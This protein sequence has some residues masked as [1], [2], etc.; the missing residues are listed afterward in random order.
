MNRISRG[1]ESIGKIIAPCPRGFTKRASS[2]L[3]KAYAYTMLV[4]LLLFT[5]T[6]LPADDISGQ[7]GMTQSVSADDIPGELKITHSVSA[8]GA[9]VASIPIPTLPGA[10]GLEPKLL[11]SYSSQNGNIGFGLG[12]ALNGY[13][14]IVRGSKTRDVDG[15]PGPI[16]YHYDDAFYL[17]GERIVPI[18]QLSAGDPAGPWW[19]PAG[20]IPKGAIEYRKW[21]DDGTLVVAVLSDGVAPYQPDVD[22]F[23]AETK[24]GIRTEFTKKVGG[25]VLPT[26][27]IY[28]PS[29]SIDTAGNYIMWNFLDTG[30]AYQLSSVEYTGLDSPQHPI[31]SFAT[32]NFAYE[33]A[34]RS[35]LS[36]LLGQ[37]LSTTQRLKTVVTALNG[38][39]GVAAKGLVLNLSYKEA[40]P[41]SADAYYLSGAQL[42]ALGDNVPTISFDYQALPADAKWKSLDQAPSGLP[43]LAATALPVIPNAAYRLGVSGTS[44]GCKN[45][46]VPAL[47]L[48]T[49]SNGKFLS[50]TYLFSA[51]NWTEA[52]GL[53]APPVPFVDPA[54]QPMSLVLMDI[55]GDK[56]TDLLQVSDKGLAFIQNQN[57]W[58]NN[59]NYQLSF[60]KLFK[61]S[62][63]PVTPVQPLQVNSYNN[64]GQDLL[65]KLATGSY[66]VVLNG[67]APTY[68]SRPPDP[69][70]SF[71]PP[72]GNELAIGDFN[73]D[74]LDDRVELFVKGSTLSLR[75][76]TSKPN[77]QTWKQE[78]SAAWDWTAPVTGLFH[79]QAIKIDSSNRCDALL[80]SI[81]DAT[82][83]QEDLFVL[84]G[85]RNGW[86]AKYKGSG[87]PFF[88][89]ND[90]TA[91]SPSFVDV[92]GDGRTDVI[93]DQIDSHQSNFQQTWIQSTQVS[94][95]IVSWTHDDTK[96][97]PPPVLISNASNYIVAPWHVASPGAVIIALPSHDGTTGATYISNASGW[98]NTSNLS[99]VPSISLVTTKQNR[100]SI[101][102]VDL[103]GHGLQDVVYTDGQEDPCGAVPNSVDPHCGA[104]FNPVDKGKWTIHN[105]FAPIHPLAKPGD[106]GAR[107]T[108]IDIN[109]DGYADLVY[110]YTENGNT[111]N[112]IYLNGTPLQGQGC[113]QGWV[114]ND[115][116]CNSWVL[117][118]GVVFTDVARGDLGCRFADIDGDGLPDIICSVQPYDTNTG[119]EP[120]IKAKAYI[121]NARGGPC[122]LP[123]VLD[124]SG[125][126]CQLLPNSY[127]LP[128]AFAF[129]LGSGPTLDLGT[130]LI[131][132]DGD[133][134]P[135]VVAAYRDPLNQ[136]QRC[137]VC[138]IYR[139]NG[140]TFASNSSGNLPVDP[141]SSL[142]LML[143]AEYYPSTDGYQIS[144]MDIDGDGLPD[145]VQFI[146][147]AGNVPA[148]AQ[149][150]LGNGATWDSSVSAWNFTDPTNLNFSGAQFVDVNGDGRPDVI[151]NVLNGASGVILNTGNGWSQPDANSNLKP[152]LPFVSLSG[153]DLGVRLIDVTGDGAPDQIQSTGT[154]QAAYS[155]PGARDGMLSFVK[156]SSSVRTCY[157]YK[158]LVD[159]GN[160]AP[161]ASDSTGQAPGIPLVPFSP[162]VWQTVT[163][164][165]SDCMSASTYGRR[166][167]TSYAYEEFR[168]DLSNSIALGF[169]R[170][171][172]TD[173][174]ADTPGYSISHVTRYRQEPHLVG[175]PRLEQT[176]VKQNGHQIVVD[177]TTKSWD[178]LH[179]PVTL[180]GV[181]EPGYLQL[182]LKKSVSKTFDLN[183][184]G[185]IAS[186]VET[187]FEYDGWLNAITVRVTKPGR[188]IQTLVSKY[189]GA[190]YGRY[191]RLT[192]SSSTVTGPDGQNVSQRT[193]AFTYF[194]VSLPQ[195]FLLKTEAIDVGDDQLNSTT[196]YKRDDRGDIITTTKSAANYLRTERGNATARALTP[197]SRSESVEYDSQQLR[198][199]IYQTNAKNQRTS[200]EYD[201][202]SIGSSLALP[203]SSTDPNNLISTKSYDGLGRKA[204][205]STPD[206]VLHHF[207]RYQSQQIPAEWLVGISS[208]ATITVLAQTAPCPSEG[209][210]LTWTQEPIGFA[211]AEQVTASSGRSSRFAG[212]KVYDARNR[213][214]RTVYSR[215][216]GSIARLAFTDYKYD[217]QGRLVA[218]SLAYFSGDTPHWTAYA[219]DALGRRTLTRRPNGALSRFCYNVTNQGPITDQGLKETLL[220][221]KNHETVVQLNLDGKPRLITRSDSGILS[222]SYDGM[223]RV[224]EVESPTHAMT[225][226]E[227]DGLGNRKLVRDPNAGLIEYRY[228]AFGQL[229]EE[230][231]AAQQWIEL[232]YDELGRKYHERRYDQETTLTYDKQG[233]IGHPDMTT[234]ET[235]NSTTILK[236]VESYNYDEYARLKETKTT[237]DATESFRRGGATH[238]SGTY[239]FFYDLY[240]VLDRVVYPTS[241]GR[242]GP[243]LVVK[244]RYDDATGQ[245]IQVSDVTDVTKDKKPLWR[246]ESADASGH[247]LRASYGNGTI[248]AKSFDAN[249]GRIKS[250]SVAS[251]AGKALASETYEY[252]PVGNLISRF[253]DGRD[254]EEFGYDEQNRLSCD[255]LTRV[256]ARISKE[257][258]ECEAAD[259]PRKLV[260]VSYDTDD[261]ILS[262]SDVGKY[263]YFGEDDHAQY[264]DSGEASGPDAL[265]AVERDGK[266]IDTF[267]YDQFGNVK[268]HDELRGLFHRSVEVDYTYDHHVSRL[269]V[270]PTLHDA[271]IAEFYYGSAGQRILSREKNGK[272][273][274]ETVHMGLYERISVSHT[275]LF[276]HGKN[277]TDRFYV[278]GDQGVFLTIDATDR[279]HGRSAG[280]RGLHRTALY[281]HHDRLG[282]IVLLTK[283]DGRTGARVHYDPW[284]KPLGGLDP[285][286]D[287][288]SRLDLEA[289]WT[290][291]FAGQDHIPD[292]DLVH[293]TGR[294]YDPRLGL[295]LS[296][297]PLGGQ[298]Q[299][300]GD[301]NPYLYAE[302]NPLAI[303]DPTGLWGLSDLGNAI[304]NA[305]SGIGQAIGNAITSAAS[306]VSTALQN[307]AQWVGQNWR[308]IAAVAVIAVVTFA[309]AGTGTGPV[310]A[311]TLAGAAGGATETALYGGNI[312]DVIGGALEGA[313]FGGLSA[314]LGDAGLSWET[315]ELGH[316]FVGG[317]QSAFSGQ[318]FARG[319]VIGALSQVNT[320]SIAVG[321]I[322]GWAV[323]EQ[324]AVSAVVNGAISEA[325]G[326]KFANGAL[327][328][329]FQQLYLDADQ[330]QWQIKSVIE[331]VNVL[332]PSIQP[333]LGVGGFLGAVGGIQQSFGLTT[334]QFV[335][336]Y[337][338]ADSFLNIIET[339]ANDLTQLETSVEAL[340][341]KPP[342]PALFSSGILF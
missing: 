289:A 331:A 3:S 152:W 13:S 329:A 136:A 28:L 57:G 265:C 125:K 227:F 181:L 190:D 50:K 151:Y 174:A 209:S 60:S 97:G 297:D 285:G 108:F 248:E 169:A 96:Y 153:D 22:K 133:R 171:E 232:D 24:S 25:S 34:P 249:T 332:V 86:A 301:L 113:P 339:G 333:Q 142:T 15:A 304:G 185:G 167:T 157:S 137:K 9:S 201:S 147:T 322:S 138:G 179:F 173:Q 56:C 114:P 79:L 186:D 145:M 255:A 81:Y 311:A 59:T 12:W 66:A 38:S 223:G 102:F 30:L 193:S 303:T 95:S 120:P 72:L 158:T 168:F 163:D 308:E 75:I 121:N 62:E 238:Y 112:E 126:W 292:F 51:N 300:G 313:V 239:T 93:L 266:T 170:I 336:G 165:S 217:T 276:N 32:I 67:P 37:T 162:I 250:F 70:L 210:T 124:P 252:D 52:D 115:K 61:N 312:Q 290:R 164:E 172:H 281:Q 270:K 128:A 17:D 202:N 134:L 130:Q 330:G 198:R 277:V 19:L 45:A 101:Q 325:Q 319:F 306:A 256:H 205:L 5:A 176:I 83:N 194:D 261:R 342:S 251:S 226:L 78:T 337:A 245:L 253:I 213:V 197:A 314:G 69:S 338:Q 282:S 127:S 156:E 302:G 298:T 39:S 206:K 231:S 257:R 341:P 191:G 299:T 148:H 65:V 55:D 334:A 155:N 111:V 188:A 63:L 177:E 104:Q 98:Q 100:G 43:S 228:D 18:A 27:V 315:S 288:N 279:G 224:Y 23:I 92:N 335:S 71:S 234:L 324:V 220:D 2:E 280:G 118:Q 77:S 122:N 199:V 293:M 42:T 20:S 275:G 328:G 31:G 68:W 87:G 263:H 258:K 94:G 90:G 287:D 184:T 259:R 310:V 225:K 99:F 254:L 64:V 106:L 84:Q 40:P 54:G 140:G 150:Y 107:A 132:L 131:D 76:Y 166:L 271:S 203:T 219:Y 283:S 211:E 35:L 260:S 340:K 207:Y 141:N 295:F 187:T 21:V 243:L 117:P 49:Y 195:R 200:L 82:Q 246:L 46:P 154:T 291:G 6:P 189:V 241:L 182:L 175:H 318:D 212:A 89:E 143:D 229:R 268:N 264:C 309:T 215:T 48:S 41:S 247:T 74:G 11:L 240:S 321:Y 16:T 110:S 14:T 244:R 80:V 222:L 204:T 233:A 135:A 230:R 183:G 242:P 196:T 129:D 218:Q 236:Y 180:G 26:P 262:K 144:F 8:A 214:I 307:A 109:G 305:I 269:L 29:R 274:K 1:F 103:E 116:K 221:A 91:L 149:V 85:S 237:L 33:P 178:E 161:I 327:T 146:P 44:A 235:Q 284:G 326:D 123:N 53:R 139:N 272:R 216:D 320:S 119:T 7:L 159:F 278:L 316:G 36:H 47:F 267:K 317:I 105:E 88:F 323:A 286:R 192:E 273:F 296:V 73:G 4:L 160:Y 294:V 208:I 58:T 10:G